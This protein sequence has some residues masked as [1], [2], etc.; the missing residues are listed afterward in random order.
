MNDNEPAVPSHRD[1]GFVRVRLDIAYDGTDFAGWAWQRGTSLRTVQGEL[2]LALARVLRRDDRVPTTCS[3]RTD[4][5]VHARGQVVHADLTPEEWLQHAADLLRRL[6]SALPTDLRVRAVAIAP[7][8]FDARFSPISR[9][10]R[11][12]LCDRIEQLDPLRRHEVVVVKHPLNVAAMNEAAVAFLG[13]HDFAAFCKQ[14]EGATTVRRLIRCSFSRTADGLVVGTI[15]AD[16][17]C[18][19]MVRS[20]VG[21]FLAVG[22]GRQEPSWAAEVLAGRERIPAVHVAPAHGLTL[23]AVT[24]PP[25]AQLAARADAVRAA[26]PR[27]T[28]GTA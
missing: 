11:Y 2:E 27:T 22:D 8:G 21:A 4:A 16:A 15:E 12:R 20:L 14:R 26:G 3:G 24:F 23:E 5:G 1:G 10:Y 17:F 25:E 18:H 19:S 13:E 9:T 6:N 7:H 28:P